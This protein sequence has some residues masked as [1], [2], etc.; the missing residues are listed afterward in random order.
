VFWA[1]GVLAQN[2]SPHL[3]ITAKEM[4]SIRQEWDKYPVFRNTFLDAKL[5]IDSV[6]G[7]TIDVPI[8]KDA[9]GYTHERHKQNY[10]EMYLA[11]FLYQVTGDKKYSDFVKIMLLKYAELYPTLKQHPEAASSSPGRLFWQSLNEY[12]WL[13]YTTQAYDCVC[14]TFSP[15]ERKLI[16]ENVFRKMAEYFAIERVEELDLIHNHGTY[17]CAAVGMAGFVLRDQDLI[18]K[19]L[20]GSKKDSTSGFIAQIK[21]LISP[22]GYYTEGAYY[23]RYEL[24]PLFVFAKAIDNNIPALNI[25]KFRDGIFNKVLHATLQQTAVDGK[26]LPFNDGVKDKNYLSPEVMTA[27]DIVFE[28]YGGDN[29]L[30]SIANKQNKVLL[31]GAGLKVAKALAEA[32]SIPEYVRKSV[33]YTDGA[34]GNEGGLSILRYGNGNDE[35]MVAYKYTAHGLS[36]G[37]YD[38]LSFIYYDNDDEILKDYGSARFVNVDQKWGGRYLPEN[39]S[40]AMQTVA[41]NTLVVDEKTQFGGK[42]DISEKYHPDAYF[43]SAENQK[44]KISSAKFSD[45]TN[46]VSIQRTIAL[47]KI[48]EL[49][50][51]IVIDVIRAVSDKVHSY[52]LPFYYAGDFISTNIKYTANDKSLKPLGKANGYQHLWTYGEGKADSSLQVTWLKGDRFYSL[53]SSVDST[54]NLVFSRI[55]ASDPKY[56]LRNDASF[57]IRNK[58]KSCVIASVVEPHGKYDSVNEFT[59]NSYP[60]IQSVKVIKDGE[61]FTAVEISGNNIDYVLVVCNNDSSVKSTHSILLNGK[62]YKWTGQFCLEK[63][64]GE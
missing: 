20:Y 12:N 10:T 13:F 41:H 11:G 59:Q 8:P 55:G 64:K 42:I 63:Y 30:L 34:N 28:I 44:L 31:S 62:N 15:S 49:A 51:P 23:A 6:V 52:D 40:F 3:V 19:A 38:K 2:T 22:D 26:F 29:S 53:T 47:A 46:P 45:V 24:L 5:K 18:D 21:T 7:K 35:S 36:H 27:L 39:K 61:D 25:F 33:N 54:T 57:M 50:N 32:K 16:E 17:S 43:F 9:A 48:D 60:Q 1:N 58:E 56:D 37:H 4:S 14:E